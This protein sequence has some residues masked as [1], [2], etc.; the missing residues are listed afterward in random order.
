MKAV[1][2]FL[3]LSTYFVM[4]I[5][6]VIFAFNFSVLRASKSFGI[7]KTYVGGAAGAVDVHTDRARDFFS[8]VNTM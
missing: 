7:T 2:T 5:K 8:D 4:D 1:V 6:N 3:S